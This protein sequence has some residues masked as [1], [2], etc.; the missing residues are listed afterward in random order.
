M[1]PL[2]SLPP[3][4]LLLVGCASQTG[5]VRLVSLQDSLDPLRPAFNAQSDRPRILGLFSPT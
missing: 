5:E 1:N 4:L 2:I 3:F